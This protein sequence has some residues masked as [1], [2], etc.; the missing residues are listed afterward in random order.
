M[1]P[2]IRRRSL[3]WVIAALVEALNGI[4]IKGLPSRSLRPSAHRARGCRSLTRPTP[5]AI[6]DRATFSAPQRR[7]FAE[8][9][10]PQGCPVVFF[11]SGGASA[12]SRSAL[13]TAA[14]SSFFLFF[15]S[16]RARA[17][18]CRSARARL[19]FGLNAMGCLFVRWVDLVSRDYICARV[20]VLPVLAIDLPAQARCW[21]NLVLPAVAR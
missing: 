18:L 15:S 17:A 4:A 7:C 19:Q 6:V 8:P 13:R 14:L 12:V 2:S 21:G 3:H 20:R 11:S 16:V 1:P 5:K 10:T 9:V